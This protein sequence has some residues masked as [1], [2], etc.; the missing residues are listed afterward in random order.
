MKLSK[1]YISFAEL[2]DKTNP[3]CRKMPDIFYPEDFGD[4]YD[5]VKK[6]AITVCTRCPIQVQC[7]EYALEADEE[8]GVW[9]GK[10]AAQRRYGRS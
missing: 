2:A 8:F 7:L 5:E 9:G 3:R 4:E 6:K 10:T 1:R